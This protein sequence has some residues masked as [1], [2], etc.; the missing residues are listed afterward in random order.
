V[1]TKSENILNPDSCWNKAANDEPVFVLR[2]T[3]GAAPDL[4][5]TW[6]ALYK[7][8]TGLRSPDQSRKYQDALNVADAM[9][10]FKTTL[11]DDDIPF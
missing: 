4:V 6:A 11:N 2:S 8:R 3:D 5:R 7:H 9:G 10:R 1:S